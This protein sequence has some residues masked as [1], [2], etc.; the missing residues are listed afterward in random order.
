MLTEADQVR[1]VVRDCRT[2]YR[3]RSALLLKGE[4]VISN[5]SCEDV[6]VV[7]AKG[8]AKG[9][10]DSAFVVQRSENAKVPEMRTQEGNQVSSTTALILSTR[11]YGTN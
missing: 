8:D 3:G 7:F 6:Y 11:R 2:S 1:R 5:G 4:R 9:E 10:L